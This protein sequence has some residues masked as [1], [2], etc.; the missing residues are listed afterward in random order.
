MTC[1][2]LSR[3]QL[4][5][6]TYYRYLLVTLLFTRCMPSP[7]S[8]NILILFNY[9]L[10]ARRRSCTGSEQENHNLVTCRFNG[11]FSDGWRSE[12]AQGATGRQREK[13]GGE[14]A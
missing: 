14:V 3:R 8:C 4:I 9:L 11:L 12:F 6:R 10:E 13:C 1:S 7:T 5:N 2:S